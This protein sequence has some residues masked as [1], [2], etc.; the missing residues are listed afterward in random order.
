LDGAGLRE[1]RAFLVES[2]ARYREAFR[3]HVRGRFVLMSMQAQLTKLAD[4]AGRSDL[5]MRLLA[6]MGGV[7]ETELADD[8]WQVGTGTL[9]IDEFVRRHGFQGP[10]G[11]NV[12]SVSWRESHVAI[13]QLADAM[14]ARPADQRPRTREAA[15]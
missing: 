10:N 8:L 7:A 12:S 9:S 15:T 6:G 5:V 4:A 14:V 11:G 13:L 2:A 1:A 3:A